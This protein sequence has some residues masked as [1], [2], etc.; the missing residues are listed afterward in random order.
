MSAPAKPVGALLDPEAVKTQLINT[1]ITS[2]AL[3]LISGL[4]FY[5]FV[6]VPA[7]AVEPARAVSATLMG[8]GQHLCKDWQG[9]R[10][11]TRVS[12]KAY[13][14][15]CERYAQFSQLEVK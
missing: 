14:F 4:L 13:T 7:V 9:L 15:T 6:A 12:D 1:A 5:H 2:Y 3:G 8:V 11:I 10:N